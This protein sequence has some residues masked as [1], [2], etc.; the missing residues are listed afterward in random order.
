MARRFHNVA[1]S[2]IVTTFHTSSF[3]SLIA[4]IKP[5][6]KQSFQKGTFLL[7]AL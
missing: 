7:F 4:A 2:V 6:A 5:K 3:G 1:L